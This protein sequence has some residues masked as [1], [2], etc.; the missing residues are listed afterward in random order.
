MMNTDITSKSAHRLLQQLESDPQL[1]S[2]ED[3]TER[4]PKEYTVC[5]ARIVS[6]QYECK[7]ERI[8]Y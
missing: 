7:I 8:D 1:Q 6:Q 3:T 2:T 4:I 5:R